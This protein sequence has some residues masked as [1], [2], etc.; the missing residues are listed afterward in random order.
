MPHSLRLFVCSRTVSTIVF[1]QSAQEPQRMHPAHSSPWLHHLSLVLGSK[2]AYNKLMQSTRFDSV[3]LPS[4]TRLRDPSAAMVTA[5]LMI[6]TPTRP[7]ICTSSPPCWYSSTRIAS[8]A[9]VHSAIPASLII[10]TAKSSASLIVDSHSACRSAS[11]SPMT[12]SLITRWSNLIDAMRTE[13]LVALRI[14]SIS[15]YVSWFE[16]PSI[17]TMKAPL[18]VLY[19]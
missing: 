16:S 9:C 18:A 13:E 5:S 19:S 3:G 11:T 14:S 6:L 12:D 4:S 2:K 8:S 7:T 15:A 17:L 10:S 1:A